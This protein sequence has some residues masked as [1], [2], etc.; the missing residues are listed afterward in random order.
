MLYFCWVYKWEEN[1]TIRNS[2][3]HNFYKA[4]VYTA[5]RPVR[6][7]IYTQVG[8]TKISETERDALEAGT[9]G[10]EADLLNGK[11]E[12]KNIL[13]IEKPKLSKKEQEFLDGPVEEL[14]NMLND[15]EIR[16]SPN[17]DM[18]DEVWQFIKDNKFFGMVIPEEHGGLGFS[19]LAQSEVVMKLSS[20][21][22]S[23]AV[24]VMVPNS[25]GP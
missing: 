17:A 15:W 16:N 25:L 11:P 19:A 5:L 7:I 2:L 10:F 12:W 18:P 8:R 24:T 13:D 6:N 4:A 9:A 21:S 3:V 1:M 23:A 22:T 20:R 14:C